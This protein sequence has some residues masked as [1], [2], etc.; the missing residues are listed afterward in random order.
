M[1]RCCICA[2]AGLLQ[3]CPSAKLH[4]RLTPTLLITANSRKAIY[5][6][7]WGPLRVLP[8]FGELRRIGC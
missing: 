6:L 7:P 8:C 2:N 1:Q 3:G 4:R 5:Y